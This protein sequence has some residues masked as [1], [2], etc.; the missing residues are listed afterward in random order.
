[1]AIYQ[2]TGQKSPKYKISIEIYTIFMHPQ[3][4]DFFFFNSLISAGTQ[5]LC[6]CIFCFVLHFMFT[7]LKMNIKESRAQWPKQQ[8]HAL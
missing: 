6:G 7:F 3:R 1:M 5:R 2:F 8:Q 4:R